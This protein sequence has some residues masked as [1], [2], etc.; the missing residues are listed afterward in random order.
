EEEE[1]EEEEKDGDDDKEDGNGGDT[2]KDNENQD[3]G[4][5]KNKSSSKKKEKDNQNKKT[6]KSKPKSP[7]SQRN[8]NNSNKTAKRDKTPPKQK[9][10]ASPS[11]SPSKPSKKSMHADEGPATGKNNSEKGSSNK[12]LQKAASQPSSNS[13]PVPQEYVFSL[14]FVY[15][16][17]MYSIFSDLFD[18]SKK[19]KI[20]KGVK[21]VNS[22]KDII[23]LPEHYQPST[24]PNLL[25]PGKWYH[26]E[27]STT[28]WCPVHD[29]LQK[30]FDDSYVQATNS[31]NNKS[32]EFTFRDV[33]YC[34]IFELREQTP[35]GRQQVVSNSSRFRMIIRKEPEQGKINNINVT[36]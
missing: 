27:E 5:S 23:K 10:S 29:G 26:F 11:P 20:L 32:K 19:K 22:V 14:L 33:S 4:N 17:N 35:F 9:A 24:Y 12:S 8:N 6:S 13:N 18:V 31:K 28:N 25:G 21:N 16:Y 7:T 15:T 3:K 2:G 36:E 30:Y 34:L 1:E